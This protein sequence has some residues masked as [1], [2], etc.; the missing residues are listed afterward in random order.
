MANS[1]FLSRV[2]ELLATYLVQ[3]TLFLGGVCWIVV[4]VMNG[5][6][7][8][9]SKYALEG[10]GSCNPFVEERLWKLAAV[11]PLVTAP[12]CVCTGWSH[13]VLEWS[14]N[15]RDPANIASAPDP[16]VRGAADSRRPGIVIAGRETP[17]GAHGMRLQSSPKA[18]SSTPDHTTNAL[19][20]MAG[21]GFIAG[22]SMG[23]S[24]ISDRRADSIPSTSRG[25]RDLGSPAIAGAA[26]HGT[27]PASGIRAIAE[28]KKSSSVE[29]I[30][31][32]GIAS[33]GWI[34]LCVVRVGIR[35]VSI[36]RFLTGCHPDSGGMRLE[37]DRLTPRGRLIR[38]LRA[39]PGL[40]NE[41]FACGLWNWTIVLPNGIEKQLAP[42]ETRALLAHELAHLLRRDPCWLL[43]G[44]LICTCLIFQPL[45]LLARRNWQQATELLCDDW[46][47][48]Q[49]IS[50]AA[51]ANCLTRIAEARLDRRAPAWGLAAA[52]Q[53]GSLTRR[54]QWLMRDR[55]A[56]DSPPARGLI[57]VTAV[58]FMTG[59]LVG[60]FGPR[61][62][63]QKP[64][65]AAIAVEGSAEWDHFIEELASAMSELHQ[66]ESLLAT[67]PDP[68]I[69]AAGAQIHRRLN[70]IR[71]VVGIEL[72]SDATVT[73]GLD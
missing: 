11:L 70:S 51:L 22:E 31:R 25:V 34:T 58:A 46:A 14:V 59:I 49:N 66:L 10:S 6:R 7:R 57:G 18:D 37:L 63:L 28:S 65:E 55:R 3:S 43:I 68:R 48:R 17:Q 24:I 20:S 61:F 72:E 53:P 38:L 69:S 73:R 56:A 26:P 52:G 50:A 9:R 21:D 39:D 67:E 13:P 60:S 71:E 1:W 33:L 29:W 12:L 45:N 35:E 47:V 32:L 19:H 36:L 44:E 64:L 27:L 8:A 15:G 41:P 4:P 54:I 42:T 40:A 23:A 62:T 2:V 5:F 16:Q 30:A